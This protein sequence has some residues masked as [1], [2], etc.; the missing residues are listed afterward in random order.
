MPHS[1][2]PHCAYIAV[3][4][5]SNN[6][7]NALNLLFICELFVTPKNMNI[8]IRSIEVLCDLLSYDFPHG[9]PDDAGW[10]SPKLA[11]QQVTCQWI[12]IRFNSFF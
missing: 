10:R 6:T 4:L 9:G 2:R 3:R 11:N 7:N 5:Q 12:E 8:H 1:V